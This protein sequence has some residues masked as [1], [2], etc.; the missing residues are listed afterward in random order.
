[1]EVSLLRIFFIFFDTAAGSL[2]INRYLVYCGISYFNFS[3]RRRGLQVVDEI[4][5]VMYGPLLGIWRYYNNS[6]KRIAMDF[7]LW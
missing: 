6:R 2:G 4:S 1:M 5:I 7:K 3:S